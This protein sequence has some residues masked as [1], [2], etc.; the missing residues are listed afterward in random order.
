ML[1]IAIEKPI[2]E[3]MDNELEDLNLTVESDVLTNQNENNIKEE[4][5][6]KSNDQCKIII[7]KLTIMILIC[8]TI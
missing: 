3:Y 6:E 5:G 2:L 1:P 7:F 8:L 4:N